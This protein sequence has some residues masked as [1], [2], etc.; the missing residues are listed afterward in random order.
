MF[1]AIQSLRNKLQDGGCVFGSFVFSRDASVT[2]AYGDAGFDFVVIDM[3]HALNDMGTTLQHIRVCE[4]RGLAS[5]VRVADHMVGD[6]P[7]L[8]DAGA[9]GIM[10][11]H[12]GMPGSQAGKALDTFQYPPAG[13]RPTC[14][15]IR[16][17]A[18]GLAT[19]SRY[20]EEA[21]RSSFGIGLVEDSMA[22]DAVDALAGDA[23][24]DCLMP[25]PGDLAS[26]LGVHGNLVHP[27]V[28]RAVDKVI[29]SA[30][31]R[32]RIA[33]MYVNQASE[34]PLWYAKGARLFVYSID[35]KILARTLADAI[36]ACRSAV[37][38]A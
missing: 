9:G 22:V 2:E 29:A 15:G 23:R 36:S 25:G 21:N 24:L 10:L 4:A 28:Q 17:N 18:Y 35:S 6:V 5:I 38:P 20:V 30:V 13:A 14:T 3:E 27:L 26:S 19:F 37:Q 7:R 12:V 1:Q 31:A 32:G 11:P 34:V 33:G 16:A 8:L